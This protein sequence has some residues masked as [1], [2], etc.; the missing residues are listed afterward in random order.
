MA[1]TLEVAY[2]L[3]ATIT[4]LRVLPEID[5]GQLQQLDEYE[6]GLSTR[7]LEE[8]QANAQAYLDQLAQ[9]HGRPGLPIKVEVRTGP[10]AAAILKYAELHDIDLIG[11]ATHGRTGLRRWMYGSVMEKV[12]HGA[13]CSMLVVR[14]G[15]HELR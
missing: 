8:L 3:G 10:A 9:T 14:P 5:M 2:G 15:Q 13:T 4:L 7:L 1:P 11:M 6:T 12:L